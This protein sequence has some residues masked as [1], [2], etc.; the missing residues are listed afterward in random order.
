M[1]D[2]PARLVIPGTVYQVVSLIGRGGMGTVYEVEDTT[3]GKRYVL[4]TLHA[5]LRDHKD[6]AGASSARRARSRA[7]S[8]RTSSTWSPRA[9]PRTRCASRTS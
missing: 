7:C 5:A 9:S 4:K 8:M 6:L 2:Y 1:S 3:V